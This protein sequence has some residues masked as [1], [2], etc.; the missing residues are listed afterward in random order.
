MTEL[1]RKAWG[2][3]LEKAKNVLDRTPMNRFVEL[4]EVC[5]GVMYWLSNAS[6][7]IQGQRIVMDGGFTIM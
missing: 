1:A 6:N 2:E 7:M 5:N 4:E 3:N